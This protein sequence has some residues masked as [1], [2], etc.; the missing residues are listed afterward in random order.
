MPILNRNSNKQIQKLLL[1]FFFRSLR[2]KKREREAEREKQADRKE[3]L[4]EQ[5]S[6]EI[7]NKTERPAIATFTQLHAASTSQRN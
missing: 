5:K 2:E 3:K 7:S 1:F 4:V 6:K